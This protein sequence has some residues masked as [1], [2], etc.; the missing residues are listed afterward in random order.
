M[1]SLVVVGNVKYDTLAAIERMPRRHEKLRSGEIVASLGGSGANTAAWLHYWGC[2]VVLGGAVGGDRDG[3]QCIEDL[4]AQDIDCS[5]MAVVDGAS[6]GRGVCLSTP[7]EKRIITTSGP[8]IELALDGL[9]GAKLDWSNRVLH[10]SCKE[11]PELIATCRQASAGGALVSAELGGRSLPAV[12]E[13]ASLAFMNHDELQRVFGVRPE[14]LTT[15]HVAQFLPQPDA[16]LVVTMGRGGAMCV[17][18]REIS[19]APS[20]HV[21]LVERTGAGDAFNAGFLSAWVR[22]L[23][24][25]ECLTQGN[26][27]SS[28]VLGLLGAQPGVEMMARAESERAQAG[29]ERA[30]AEAAA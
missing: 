2:E 12:R 24:D 30:H 29:A 7:R 28:L 10:V 27:S 26:K 15:E 6:T 5:L 17:S 22:G 16:R 9:R 18:A 21:P 1:R 19:H 13:V 25:H 20:V 23:S 14:E 11:S 8:S 3:R 4:Q